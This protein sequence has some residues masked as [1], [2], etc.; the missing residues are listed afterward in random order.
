MDQLIELISLRKHFQPEIA[1]A[2]IVMK[3]CSP[4]S[5]AP[6]T[7]LSKI[8]TRLP[9]V[10]PHDR[11]PHHCPPEWTPRFT[12]FQLAWDLADTVRVSDS[13]TLSVHF[14]PLLLHYIHC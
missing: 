5:L 4:S 12:A 9:L 7:P 2:I 10:E 6:R 1:T 11:L 14:S 8:T 3:L 13:Y